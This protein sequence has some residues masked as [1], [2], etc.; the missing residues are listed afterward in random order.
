M[1]KGEQLSTS[2]AG[3]VHLN[4]F[5][6]FTKKK[7]LAPEVYRQFHSPKDTKLL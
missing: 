5:H 1:R 3:T 7:V 4:S 2:W 6:V